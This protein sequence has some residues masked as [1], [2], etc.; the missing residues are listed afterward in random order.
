MASSKDTGESCWNDPVSEPVNIHEDG[1]SPTESAIELEEQQNVSETKDSLS[2]LE[3]SSDIVLSLHE[4]MDV[5]SDMPETV[6][7][8]WADSMDEV[9]PERTYGRDIST[10]ERQENA[11]EDHMPRQNTQGSRDNWRPRGVQVYHDRWSQTRATNWRGSRG[12]GF[13]SREPRD[14]YFR[15]RGFRNRD[16][17]SWE[18][19]YRGGRRP[20][21]YP[22]R[23]IPRGTLAWNSQERHDDYGLTSTRGRDRRNLDQDRGYQYQRSNIEQ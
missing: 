23:F 11:Y 12:R 17:R 4:P 3:N 9:G 22:Q 18:P 20:H 13:G 10:I 5:D 19:S 21:R 16:F 2:D 14:R 7:E 6:A 15:G 8:S 1:V